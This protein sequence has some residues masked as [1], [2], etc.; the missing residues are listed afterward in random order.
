MIEIFKSEFIPAD[1]IV[2]NSGQIKGLPKNPRF[3]R[4][5]RF[6][7]LKKSIQDNPEFLGGREILVFKH[8]KNFVVIGGNMRLQACKDLGMETIPCKIIPASFTTEQ[9]KALVIKDNVS[10]GEID[11]ESI[12][13][14]WELN[15]LKDFGM[16]IFV[17]TDIDYFPNDDTSGNDSDSGF[18]DD[19]N[20]DDFEEPDNAIGSTQHTCPHCNEIFYE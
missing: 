13:N 10:F 19:D 5:N 12:A 18:N 3:I 4:N 6:Q 17:N 15:D 7:A 8:K 9:L 2:T 20:D 1:E 14:E 11:W 16:E